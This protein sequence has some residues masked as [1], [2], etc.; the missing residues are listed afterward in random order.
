M[1]G[2]RVWI[3]KETPKARKRDWFKVG[4]NEETCVLFYIFQTEFKI[5]YEV[6]IIV[7][8]CARAHITR[9]IFARNS[10]IRRMNRSAF[11]KF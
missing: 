3:I 10:S 1:H 5:E 8:A 4:K 9:K 2:A 6:L 7:C 11:E